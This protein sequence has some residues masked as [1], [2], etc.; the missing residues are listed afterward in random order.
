MACDVDGG[1]GGADDVS[2]V[3]LSM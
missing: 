2:G 1:G 3:F